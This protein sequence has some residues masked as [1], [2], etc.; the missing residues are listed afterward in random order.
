MVHTQLDE[1]CGFTIELSYFSVNWSLYLVTIFL[2]LEDLLVLAEY[3]FN[4][5]H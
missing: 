3:R 1:M 5:K 4:Q 2:I